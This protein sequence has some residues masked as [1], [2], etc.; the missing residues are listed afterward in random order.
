MKSG[1]MSPTNTIC[2]G[3]LDAGN[4]FYPCLM[5]WKLW[6]EVS[7]GSR[8]RSWLRLGGRCS[9]RCHPRGLDFSKKLIRIAHRMSGNRISGGDAQ[10]LSSFELSFDHVLA[11]FTLLRT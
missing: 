5:H 4:S 9:A 1:S 11:N 6:E 8:L 3:Q 7:P 2:L 10:H